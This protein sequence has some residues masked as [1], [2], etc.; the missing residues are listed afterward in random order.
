MLS[1][2]DLVGTL[3]IRGGRAMPANDYQFV[4]RWR[5]PGTVEQMTDLL[6]DTETLIRIWPSLYTR[7]TI[8]SRATSGGSAR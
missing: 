1:R 5:L 4:T 3:T 2:D 8:V 6:D 7:A